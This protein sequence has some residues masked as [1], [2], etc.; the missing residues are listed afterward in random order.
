M[1]HQHLA[2]H[3]MSISFYTWCDFTI[4]IWA[5][6]TT[7]SQHFILHLLIPHTLN[8]CVH[9]QKKA[10]TSCHYHT[11]RE[12]TGN[13]P[14]QSISFPCAQTAPFSRATRVR[15]FGK[16]RHW[17]IIFPAIFFST[18]TCS[19]VLLFLGEGW[20]GVVW[21]G[22]GGRAAFVLFLGEEFVV[23]GWGI[24]GVQCTST[25]N[26]F[27]EATLSLFGGHVHTLSMCLQVQC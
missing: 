20:K 27:A 1:H 26:T 21:R 4:H 11:P 13:T 7:H 6:H 10:N 8:I 12:N 16:V 9:T 5:R 14:S 15:S 24:C 25:V 2:L 3:T 23:C 22:A 17:I 18:G 19:G